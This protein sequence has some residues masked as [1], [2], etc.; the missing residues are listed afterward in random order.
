[1][2]SLEELEIDAIIK[3]REINKGGDTYPIT[4]LLGCAEV[5]WML[6]NGCELS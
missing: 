6:A 4:S 3:G 2:T 1:M 5:R